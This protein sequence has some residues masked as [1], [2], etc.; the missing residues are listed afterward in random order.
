MT[1]RAPSTNRK[2]ARWLVQSGFARIYT[3]TVKLFSQRSAAPDK[4]IRKNCAL[5]HVTKPGDGQT[6]PTLLHP[7]VNYLHSIEKSADT[8]PHFSLTLKIER[9]KT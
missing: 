1:T 2:S 3:N 5:A 8:S 6:A 4:K 7:P 9:V